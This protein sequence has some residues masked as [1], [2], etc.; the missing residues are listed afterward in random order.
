M[1]SSRSNKLAIKSPVLPGSFGMEGRSLEQTIFALATPQGRGG[2]AV[3][4]ISGPMAR[5]VLEAVFDT[6]ASIRPRMLHYGH[7]RNQDGA[8]LDEAMAVYMPAPHTY[9][10]EDVVELQ[11]HGSLAV[12]H[13]VLQL[14]CELPLGLRPAQPGEFTRRAFENGRIDL[15]QAEAVME[16][17]GAESQ[18]A[19]HS[20]L[21]QLQGS[22][23]SAVHALID[24]L[25]HALACIEAGVDFPE[26]D[27][28]EEANAEGF[29]QLQA[30]YVRAASLRES[31][32]SGR[33]LQ[34]GV[35]CAIVGRPNVG[36]SSLLNAAAGYERALVAQEAGTTRDVVEHAIALDGVTLRLFDTAGMRA[37]AQGVESR[38]MAL[39]QRQIAQADVAIWVVDASMP[40]QQDDA[41]A[42]AQLSGVPVVIALNKSDLPAHLTAEAVA[43]QC[44]QALGVHR[45]CANTGE[46]VQALLRAA[47][48]AAGVGE[49]HQECITN[50]RHAEVLSRACTLL[51]ASLQ[52]YADGIP[53]DIAASDA[54][55]ALRALGEITGQTLDDDV[56]ARIFAQ[57][58]V[59]K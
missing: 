13:D 40:L 37:E 39:G 43:A 20:S 4:R 9:T 31:Y 30:V 41:L 36:K 23:S 55:E 28:E 45:C 27:W 46:G 17:I 22:V 53:A 51:H 19:A 7:I 42:C 18:R 24:D 47:L 38:G 56:I 6:K 34:E 3:I 11:L 25:T 49:Q 1:W 52:A 21:L 57:F 32:R 58:C 50:A 44:P 2:I 33:L 26:D 12:V 16:L 48:A 8:M 29:A 14:L 15:S 35:R 59:G 54:R 5:A 10:R